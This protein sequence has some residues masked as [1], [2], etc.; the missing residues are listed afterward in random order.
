MKVDNL[1]INTGWL[2]LTPFC[3]NACSFC[4]YV[5]QNDNKSIMSVKDVAKYSKLLKKLNV[6]TVIL[7]GGEPTCHPEFIKIVDLLYKDGHK[8]SIVSNGYG[9]ANKVICNNTINKLKNITLSVE[10]SPRIHNKIVGNKNAYFNI[11]QSILNIKKYRPELLNTNTVVSKG[12]IKNIPLCIKELYKQGV[13]RF[14]FN[15]CTSFEK[16]NYAYSPK[17]F[18]SAFE[19]ILRKLIK[20]YPVAKFTVLSPMPNCLVPKDLKGYFG[21]R[22]HIFLNSGLIIDSNNDILLCTHWVKY[23]IARIN[24]NITLLEFKKLWQKLRKYRAKVGRYP[25]SGCSNCKENKNCCGGC[26]IF[27][28]VNNPK[29]ELI[30]Q[31]N[32]I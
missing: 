31:Y 1:N 16:G 7:I 4:Y 2:T 24:P 5:N 6:K 11:K 13:R 21:Y 10:G 29:K 23:P 19:N 17:K 9:Y 3:N 8:I 32:Y 25:T 22:C 27:W 18:M 12:N 20:K 28:R 26:P 15:I 14:G 30:P